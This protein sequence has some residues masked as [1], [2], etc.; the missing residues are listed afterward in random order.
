MKTSELTDVV[1][2]VLTTTNLPAAAVADGLAG[3]LRDSH[4]AVVVAPPG[5]G[6]STLLP[7]SLLRSY[8]SGRIVMLEPRRIAARQVA[9][10]MAALLGERVGESVGYQVRFERKVSA[11][12]RIEVVTEGVLAR[13]LAD[14]PTLDGVSCVVFDEFHE[15]SLQ[16]DLTLCM[17][18][19][20][21]DVLRPDLDIVVM[22]A[23]I[24]TADLCRELG[25][26]GGEL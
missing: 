9:A 16:S 7:L 12:T 2:R 13:R 18:R 14:D 20:V 21:R 8:A 11:A 17:V 5:A 25:A 26:E 4:A 19:Q 1:T 23:T 10:R 24:D 22:S 6:K 3:A 15:R